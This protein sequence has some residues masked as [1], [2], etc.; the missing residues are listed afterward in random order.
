VPLDLHPKAIKLVG[1]FDGMIRGSS[2]SCKL[3][4]TMPSIML[5]VPNT[6]CIHRDLKPDTIIGLDAHGFW[7]VFDVSRKS[8]R[9]RTPGIYQADRKSTLYESGMCPQRPRRKKQMIPTLLLLTRRGR[10]RM[11]WRPLA[12]NKKRRI[13]VSFLLSRN[14]RQSTSLVYRFVIKQFNSTCCCF[15]SKATKSH[16]RE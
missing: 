6:F 15:P 8:A 1:L 10:R 11:R 14:H 9:R 7:K 13:L 3:A 12:R 4:G 2:S 16:C 5:C